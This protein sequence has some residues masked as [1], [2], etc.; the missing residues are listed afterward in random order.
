MN[1]K[2]AKKRKMYDQAD[3]NM[4]TPGKTPAPPTAKRRRMLTAPRVTIKEVKSR[5]E[6]EEESEDVQDE[7]EWDGKDK[8]EQSD[9]E[10]TQRTQKSQKHPKARK[11][12][13]VYT[14][15]R[16]IRPRV[17]VNTR[18][19]EQEAAREERESEFQ[20]NQLVFKALMKRG[21]PTLPPSQLV[22]KV[23][24]SVLLVSNLL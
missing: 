20:E 11:R 2:Q 17:Y 16:E 22:P 14:F 13:S 10:V 3:N 8:G 9:E 24:S 18:K 12:G 19:A 21:L 6:N 4:K 1:A 7:E 15:E 5:P 23:C